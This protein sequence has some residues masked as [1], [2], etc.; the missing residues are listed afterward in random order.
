[1][2]EEI[3][4]EMKIPV[5]RAC[6]IVSLPRCQFYYQRAKDDQEVIEALQ[7]LAF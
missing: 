4:R 7:D 5:S 1:L 3:V 2:S 6:K